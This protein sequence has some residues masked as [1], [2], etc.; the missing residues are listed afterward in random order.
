MG[1]GECES[2]CVKHLPVSDKPCLF[3]ESS[4]MALSIDRVAY[5]GKPKIL[6][7]DPDLMGPSGVQDSFNKCGFKESFDGAIGGPG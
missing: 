4:N 5:Q 2:S 7:M 6:K 3:S 1:M